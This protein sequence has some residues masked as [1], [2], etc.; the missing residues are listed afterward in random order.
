MHVRTRD[1]H[2]IGYFPKKVRKKF[3]FL[4]PHVERPGKAFLDRAIYIHGLRPT[5]SVQ[6]GKK[7]ACEWPLLCRTAASNNTHSAIADQGSILLPKCT[8]IVHMTYLIIQYITRANEGCKYTAVE[9]G[10]HS[11]CATSTALNYLLFLFQ[12]WRR[13][14]AGISTGVQIALKVP[15]ILGRL[16]KKNPSKRRCKVAFVQ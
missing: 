1:S 8:A 14:N 15:E 3:T 9:C 6:T 13:S 5:S 7:L 11:A 4:F 10:L 12:T 16:G 2:F